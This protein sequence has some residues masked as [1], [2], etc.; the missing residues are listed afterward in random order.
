VDLNDSLEQGLADAA[1]LRDDGDPEGA[2][3]VLLRLEEGFPEDAS[4]LC[5]LGVLAGE[6]DAGGMAYDYFRRSLAA[7]PTDPTV[8]A[9]LGAGLAEYDDPQAESVLRLASL[10]APGLAVARLRYGTYLSREGVLDLA[11]NELQ[12]ALELEPQNPEIHREL[13]VAHLLGGDDPRAAMLLEDAV[14]LD[15]DDPELGLLHGLVL[16]RSGDEEGAAEALHA[17]GVALTEDGDVQ[18]LAALACAMQ[19]WD[20][21]AWN[22][23]ARAEAATAVPDPDTVREVEDLLEAEAEAVREFLVSQLAPGILHERLFARS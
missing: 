15:P 20:D 3:D 21:E 1:R 12:A 5:L 23:L 22:A 2:F 8:L 14:G 19:G 17:A 11:R 9:M 13:A 16:L 7:Q 10:T 4:V 6:I 18:L